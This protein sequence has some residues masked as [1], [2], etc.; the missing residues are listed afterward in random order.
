MD[1]PPIEIKCYI[2]IAIVTIIVCPVHTALQ[3]VSL[4][5]DFACPKYK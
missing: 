4:C 1:F 3:H 2:P 5:H